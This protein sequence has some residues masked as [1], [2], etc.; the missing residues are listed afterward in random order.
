MIEVVKRK[1]WIRSEDINIGLVGDNEVE[2]RQFVVR[3]SMLFD[4]DFK[5][6]IE[7]E[8]HE[9]GII[10]LEKTIAEDS[11]V[12]TWIVQREHVYQ[13]DTGV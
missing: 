9:K 3:D 13:W 5:L 10:D 7:N 6:D 4:F 2:R 8:K 1:L 12:L 11:I